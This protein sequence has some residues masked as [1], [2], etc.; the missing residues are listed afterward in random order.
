[1]SDLSKSVEEGRIERKSYSV[2][3]STSYAD[4]EQERL[5]LDIQVD[6]LY[7]DIYGIA[8]V[9]I[10]VAQSALTDS[11]RRVDTKTVRASEACQ[12]VK[13]NPV[14]QQASQLIILIHSSI[15]CSHS[16]VAPHISHLAS[17]VLRSIHRPTRTYLPLNYLSASFIQRLRL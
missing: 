11:L 14:R 6:H 3:Q 10:P 8:L 13:P 5:L 16:H 7:H 4:L 9:D 17:C 12:Y 1:M 15:N 2:V